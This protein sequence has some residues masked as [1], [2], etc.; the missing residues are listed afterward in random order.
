M[1]GKV[2]LRRVFSLVLIT[3]VLLA[4]MPERHIQAQDALP[5]IGDY[6]FHSSWGG[7]G[8]QILNPQDVIVTGA[9]K[10]YILNTEFNRITI[11]DQDG[12]IYNEIG[13]FGEDDGEFNLPLGIAINSAEEIFV[14]DTWNRRMQKFDSEGNHLLTFGTFGYGEGEI[15]APTGIAIDQSGNLLVADGNNKI[16]K[17]SSNGEYISEW[18]ATAGSPGD[19][20]YEF[21]HPSDVAIDSSG[22]IYVADAGNTRIQVYDADAIYQDTIETF[23]GDFSYNPYGIAIDSSGSMYVTGNDKIFIYNTNEPTFPLVDTWGGTGTADGKLNGPMG[24]HIQGTTGDIYVTDSGND[25][26]QVFESNGTFKTAFGTPEMVDGYFYYPKD[27]AISNDR[28]YVTDRFNDRIQVFNKDGTFLFKWGTNGVEDG[29]FDEPLGI[30]TDSS[31][32]IYVVDS[33][34]V[35]MQKFDDKGSYIAQKAIPLSEEDGTLECTPKGIAIDQADNIFITISDYSGTGRILKFDSDMIYQS[36]WEGGGNSIAVDSIGNVYTTGSNRVQSYDND[37]NF[38]YEWGEGP[39]LKKGLRGIAIDIHDDVYVMDLWNAR[40]IKYSND[41]TYLGEFG[42]QGNDPGEFAYGGEMAITDD[43]LIYVVDGENQRVQVI[44]PTLPEPDPD[45]GLLLNGNFDPNE[46][47]GT[48]GRIGL[49]KINE[50]AVYDELRSDTVQG[51]DYWVYGGPLSVA[52]S[53]IVVNE[54][55]S[56]LQLGKYVEATE[57]GI[58]EAWAYQVFYV[59]PEWIKPVLTF[60]YNVFTNDIGSKSNFIAEIQ[61]GVGLNNL[62][63][64]IIDGYEGATPEEVPLTGT[65]LGWKSVEFDL[66]P[67]RGQHIRLAFASRNLYPSSLGIWSFVEKV[68]VKDEVLKLFLPL[69]LR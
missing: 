18:G 25:R 35:R 64:I 10:V 42:T 33:N 34:N 24:I 16:I 53:S 44:A 57:Q 14:S 31:G 4:V 36:Q 8:K 1:S 7:E 56:S 15:C 55:L 66:S 45:S 49:M 29:Q 40:I 28:V 43:G 50:S 61:D 51:L 67:Y 60:N 20:N 23:D 59:R 13:G 54:G 30:D 58:T 3:I 41:G 63:V 62:D 21:D 32:K 37:G 11:L 9:G 2:N 39:G 26:V 69:M 47:M 6:V 52:R 38:L 12:Y 17:F 46:I 48:L 22:N 27:A 19:G 68:V 5:Y 65:E